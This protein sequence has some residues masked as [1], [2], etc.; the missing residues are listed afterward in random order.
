MN[1]SPRCIRAYRG[2]CVGLCLLLI[3]SSAVAQEAEPSLS[4]LESLVGEWSQ[5]RVAIADEQRV[6]REQ[7]TQW[8]SE[9]AL[10]KQEQSSLRAEIESATAVETSFEA[11][12]SDVAFDRERLALVLD[13]LSPLLARAER[14]LRAWPARL[15]PP[16]REPLA[17]AFQRLPENEDDAAS[18]SHG[19]RLQTIVA[20][21]SEIEKLQQGLHTVKEVLALPDGSRREMD[22]FYVGL[23]RGFAV[24]G[25]TAWAG[26]GTP[27][28][29]GWTWD[30]RPEIAAE[31]RRAVAVSHREQPAELVDLP[32][33]VLEV[34]E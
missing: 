17:P 33:R 32:L 30:A 27:S 25:D 24:S 9:I 1:R 21:Y 12:R 15:P 10:L 22:V 6:W 5:L 7:E 34:T 19:A 4:A 29:S 14:D 2:R 13:G 11:E 31:V 16:L 3:A 28:H 8:R 20:L 26:I 23:A 18:Y